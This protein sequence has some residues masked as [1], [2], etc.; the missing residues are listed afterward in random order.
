MTEEKTKPNSTEDLKDNANILS[1]PMEQEMIMEPDSTTTTATIKNETKV[2]EIPIIEKK[3][4]FRGSIKEKN[5]SP[6]PVKGYSDE[7]NMW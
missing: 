6:F 5:P 7:E 3:T 1:K 4:G 2:E